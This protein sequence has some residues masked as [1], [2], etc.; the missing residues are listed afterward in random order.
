MEEEAKALEEA[1]RL[2]DEKVSYKNPSF[3]VNLSG[4]GIFAII[5]PLVFPC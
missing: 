2:E 4:P 3:W 1:Q 5:L